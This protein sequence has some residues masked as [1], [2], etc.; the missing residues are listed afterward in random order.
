VPLDRDTVRI[1][2]W[3]DK[4]GEIINRADIVITFFLKEDGSREIKASGL[5]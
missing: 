3:G 1:I 2:E 5:T 4:F